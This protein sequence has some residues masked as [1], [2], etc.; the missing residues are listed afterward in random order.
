MSRAR[1]LSPG[2]AWPPD[3]A[4]AGGLVLLLACGVTVALAGVVPGRPVVIAVGAVVGGA[5]LVGLLVGDWVD[6]VALVALAAPLPALYSVDGL[7][8]ATVAPVTAAV[9]LAWTLRW[10]VLRTP[11]DLGRLPVRTLGLLTGA[12][13]V[14]AVLSG[15]PATSARELLNFGVLVAFLIVATQILVARPTKV[16]EMVRLLAG[17]GALVGGLAVLEMVGLIPGRFPRW[18][19][20]FHRAAL[21]FGQ[22]NGLGLFLAMMVPLAVH[23]V[24]A[25]KTRR[26]KVLAVSAALLTVLGLVATFS[27]GSWLAVLAGTSVFL[28]TGDRRSFLR[29]WI[30]VVL[31]AG[32][33][34]VAAGGILRDTV[35]RTVGDWVIEQ[36]AVL[37]LAGVLMF[38]DHPLVGVGP[39]GFA[40]ELD[41]V[42][43]QVTALWDFQATPHNAYVQMAAETG[44]LGLLAFLAFLAAVSWVAIRSIRR[45]GAGRDA[46]PGVALRRTLLWS[47][48]TVCFA[49]FV[50]WPFSHGPGQVVMLLVALLVAADRGGE[51]G[52]PVPGGGP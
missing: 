17:A 25:S 7:R 19:T 40:P 37:M 5:A 52:S 33:I 44:I 51:G 41:R 48:A 28:F 20:P 21:G 15:H 8:V 27:R 43:A 18:D 46:G 30:G 3:A 6:G 42:G 39:G 45:V 23:E 9:V 29:I 1:E 47:F 38:L 11:T 32:V 22:P 16:P 49:G 4:V 26:G 14:A 12:F 31:L 34:D 2:W 35:E 24:R 13:A 10:S 50:V 36:R